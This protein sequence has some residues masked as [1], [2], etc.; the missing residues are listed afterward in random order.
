LRDS[1]TRRLI[2]E[3][4]PRV[5]GTRIADAY[6]AGAG[7]LVL[8]LPA[9][10]ALPANDLS[11]IVTTM[12]ALPLLF[13]ADSQDDV[14]A[15]R[16]GA[17][18][19][20]DLQGATIDAVR[21]GPAEATIDVWI[22]R[23]DHAGRKVERLLAI[24]LG[25]SPGISLRDVRKL[26]DAARE[27]RRKGMARSGLSEG[28][29][30][31]D[32]CRAAID[33]PAPSET[34]PAETAR[35]TAS[36]RHDRSGRLHVN[37][38]EGV[39]NDVEDSREFDT[40]NEAARFAFVRFWRDLE[41]ERRRAA[42]HKIVAREKKRKLRAIGK[43]QA[44][45]ERAGRA[46]EFRAM[47]H[48]LLA[49]KN[50]IP[51]GET[52]VRVL[53]FDNATTVTIDVDPALDV[54]RNAEILFRR[55]KKAE[56]SAQR[57]PQRLAELTAE[58]AG[59]SDLEDEI[60]EAEPK[61]LGRIEERLSPPSRSPA[62]RRTPDIAAR[63]R[64]YTVSGGWEVLVGKSNRDNDVVSHRIAR[65]DDIWFHAHQAAGSHVVLRRAG[66]KAEPS[67][68]AILETAAIAAYHSKAGKSSR[69]PVCYTEKRHVRK[70]RGAKP[71]LAVVK[72]EKV[73]LVEPKLPET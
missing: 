60:R 5:A 30:P 70:P 66:R 52:P 28:A 36:W 20:R 51:R 58:L 17:G 41:L 73:V 16:P 3:I 15:P 26:D 12:R 13:L 33:E 31:G 34:P 29:E 32:T 53:D 43:V 40:M 2:E 1:V 18:F 22:S 11:L 7:C 72:H 4:A 44:E 68:Q 42:A 10:G 48:L 47:A 39:P 56:R 27:D 37:I 9:R 21:P 57:T 8:T 54:A 55:A 25:G 65:P 49:R 38:T 50:T 62:R 69:V 46:D 67:R 45:I 14:P 19:E 59:L 61:T 64:T 35:P 71:G 63:Y 6:A 23:T 24:A